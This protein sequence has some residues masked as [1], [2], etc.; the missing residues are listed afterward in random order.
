MCRVRS[1]RNRSKKSR[2]LL[3]SRSHHRHLRKLKRPKNPSRWPKAKLS[4]PNRYHR[5]QFSQK[6]SRPN[7]SKQSRQ[8]VPNLNLPPKLQLRESKAAAAKPAPEIF[9]AKA[10]RRLSRDQ[11]P[12]VAAEAPL[13]LVWAEDR[14]TPGLPADT[15]LR[16]N[17]E[18]KP[19]QTVRA[20]YPPIALR[21]GMEE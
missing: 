6:R 4:N 13:A 11:V 14:V 15:P 8:K 10:T 1:N 17:R 18:A 16:T 3:R 20:V 5:R 9:S 2:R 21:M 19:I 7:R 12:P